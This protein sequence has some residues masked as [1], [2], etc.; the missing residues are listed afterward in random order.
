MKKFIKVVI[1]ISSIILI[2]STNFNGETL[3]N[4]NIIA[5]LVV[6]NN[7]N[8]LDKNYVP[9]NLVKVNIPFI[10]SISEEEKQ[11]E[12]NVALQLE[13]LVKMAS[14]EGIN[15][16]GTSGYRS[17]KSQKEIY[18]NR[19][20]SQGLKKANEYVAKPGTSEHQTGLCIDLTNEDRWFVE[21]TKEAKWLKENAHKFGFILRYPKGKEDITGK[22]FEPWHIRY[23]G[24]DIAK[25][26]YEN[27]L[28]LE[29]YVD[30]NKN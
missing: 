27:N 25:Y 3:N 5:N 4:S 12:E 28:T 7:Y 9:K 6:V 26:I 29:E 23:V 8:K 19:V 2:F 20:K 11:L 30:E 13:K 16:L 18:Y 10:D 1:I 22:K 17:Y 24:E 14:S 15:Y 21:V